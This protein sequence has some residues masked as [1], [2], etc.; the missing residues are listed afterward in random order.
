MGPCTPKRGRERSKH[1]GSC[2]RPPTNENESADASTNGRDE[3]ASA[4][5]PNGIQKP[6]LER[7]GVSPHTLFTSFARRLRR[8]EGKKKFCGDTPHP[9]KGLAALCN[10]PSQAD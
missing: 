10:P 9:S 6:I 4:L 1:R 3:H 8:R 7:G 2:P 5:L